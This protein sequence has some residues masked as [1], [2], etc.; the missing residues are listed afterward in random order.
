MYSRLLAWTNRVLARPPYG[1]VVQIDAERQRG[2]TPTTLAVRLFHEDG[3][4]LT[5]IAGESMAEQL[6]DGSAWRPGLH[7][8]GLIV[9]P[10]R[11][12]A[13]MQAWVCGS[14]PT[15]RLSRANP[16]PE[17]LGQKTPAFRRSAVRSGVQ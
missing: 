12:L 15:I 11:L 6:L 13:D 1:C 5:A 8:M 4:D 3:Y 17:L 10:E 14:R 9:D 7:R 16:W 2:G